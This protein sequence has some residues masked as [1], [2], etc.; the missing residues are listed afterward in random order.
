M[1]SSMCRMWCIPGFA[2]FRKTE[3]PTMQIRPVFL[4]LSTLVRCSLCYLM[5]RLQLIAYRS[6]YM[7]CLYVSA[8]EGRS[9]TQPLRRNTCQKTTLILLGSVSNFFLENEEFFSFNMQY[10]QKNIILM[11]LSTRRIYWAR[12]L[13]QTTMGGLAVDFTKVCPMSQVPPD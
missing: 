7:C 4:L 5:S 6:F 1:F 10:P 12:L 13:N 9:D 11:K 3:R 8:L 2:G